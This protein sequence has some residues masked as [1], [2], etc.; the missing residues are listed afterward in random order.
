M[1]TT[2]TEAS[3]TTQTAWVRDRCTALID[4]VERFIRG[5]SEVVRNAVICLLAEGHIL[6]EGNPGL[7][8]TS[9][10][11]AIAYSLGGSMKRIQFTPDLLPSDVVGVQI[12]NLGKQEFE[13]KEARSSPTLFWGMRLTGRRRRPS[14][15]CWRPWRNVRSLSAERHTTYPAQT[16]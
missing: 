3:L 12:Y 2:T 1:T 6:I 8:K 15:R 9:L 4:N 5:Q 16:S 14:R 13:F 7:A 11:K 10:A